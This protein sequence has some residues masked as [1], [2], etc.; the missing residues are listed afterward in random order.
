MIA[1]LFAVAGNILRATSL[2]YVEADLLHFGQ[3]PG[4]HE[5]I[6]LAAFVMTAVLLFAA[7]RPRT[8][9]LRSVVAA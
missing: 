7:L 5:A 2:F 3:F 4:L 1:T 6:G 8:E 9:S